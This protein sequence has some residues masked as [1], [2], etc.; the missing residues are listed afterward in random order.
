MS[1]Y[2]FDKYERFAVWK[3]H[4]PNCQWCLEPVELRHCH[5]DHIIP[6][7]LL[8]DDALLQQILV[9]Y[10]LDST[11]NINS[12]ENWIPTHSSCNQSKSD[13]VLEGIPIIQQLLEKIIRKKDKTKTL[14][15]KWKR[16]IKTAKIEFLLEKGYE[17]GTINKQ[18]IN[19]IWLKIDDSLSPIMGMTASTI[20]NQ[21]IYIPTTENWQ[22]IATESDF[23]TVKKGELT[24]ILPTSPTPDPKWLC[25]NCK[26]YGPWDG[27]LCL[28]CDE[29]SFD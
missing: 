29:V 22:V 18:I 26:N 9:K 4:G 1:Q 3:I 8:K 20:N 25:M 28:N 2:K 23:F 10:G 6:E 12:F 16:Q 21:V 5:I 7:S 15:E 27:N 14:F 13:S 24:G 11:F 19:N 17:D